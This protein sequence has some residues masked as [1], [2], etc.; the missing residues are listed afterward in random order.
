[1][2]KKDGFFYEKTIYLYSRELKKESRKMFSKDQLAFYFYLENQNRRH[3]DLIHRKI[4]WKNISN[5]YPGL[6]EC[7]HNYQKSSH[8]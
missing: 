5:T 2:E 4:I 3:V 7:N 1:M 6:W 8:R